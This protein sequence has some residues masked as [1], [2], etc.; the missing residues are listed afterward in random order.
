MARGLSTRN[1]SRPRGDASRETR[2]RSGG[3]KVGRRRTGI[4]DDPAAV[5]CAVAAAATAE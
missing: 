4:D 1:S 2:C 3:R 5:G